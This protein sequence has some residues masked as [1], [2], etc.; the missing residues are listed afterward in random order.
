MANS[1]SSGMVGHFQSGIEILKQ[2]PVMIVPPL[3]V[4][5]VMAVLTFLFIGGAATAVAVGGGAGLIGAI[6]GGFVFT[7][8]GGILSLVA[9][10]V[11]IVMA[12]DALFSQAVFGHGLSG[13]RA[14]FEDGFIYW[15][16][17]TGAHE[18]HGPVLAHFLANGKLAKFG[19]PT[20]DVIVQANGV[21][22]SDFDKGW[23]IRCPPAKACKEVAL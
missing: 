7:V 10:G 3:A 9:A 12:R 15:K 4:Q 8:I 6:M 1:S 21:Q 23:R 19:F 18:I 11:T 22:R 17:S 16:A 13:E 5:V 14:R 2:Y 20:T